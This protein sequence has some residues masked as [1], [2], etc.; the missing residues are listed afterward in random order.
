MLRAGSICFPTSSMFTL[1]LN[2]PDHLPQTRETYLLLV[3]QGTAIQ[4]QAT[5]EALGQLG[6]V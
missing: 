6:E 3:R 2:C 5:S 4:P 1:A